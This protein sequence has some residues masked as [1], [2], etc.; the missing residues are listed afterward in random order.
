VV[1]FNVALRVLVESVVACWRFRPFRA[2]VESV[3]RGPVLPTPPDGFGVSS[4]GPTVDAETFHV[5]S[6][7]FGGARIRQTVI[8]VPD[9]DDGP[10]AGSVVFWDILDLPHR[11]AYGRRVLAEC[12]RQIAW[13]SYAI[14]YD[15]ILLRTPFYLDAVTRHLEAMAREDV[16]AVLDV[17]AGTG[18]V[19][20]P[21]VKAGRAVTAVEL[22]RAMLAK[23]LDKV[24]DGDGGELHV[25]EQNAQALSQLPD[26]SFDGATVLLAF[27]DMTQPVQALR[28]VVRLLRPGGTLVVTEP[29]RTFRLQ[30]LLDYGVAMLRAEGVY[31][32]L[33]ADWDRIHHANQVL[34]PAKREASLR[35]EDI[36]ELLADDGFTDVTLVDSHLGQCA[37]VRGTKCRL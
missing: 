35:A 28:E 2:L 3:A 33:K 21:L 36:A 31:D 13:T 8:P 22:S 34:D 4:E 9:D 30:P 26:G 37:T 19:S 27:Y 20:V 23:L 14:S 16:H 11:E 10:A 29:R 5:E 7:A 6:A 17:G 12:Q 15:R 32:E 18:N 24:T 1:D 25:L